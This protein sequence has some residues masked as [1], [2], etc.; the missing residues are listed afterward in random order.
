MHNTSPFRALRA[1]AVGTLAAAALSLA[2]AQATHHPALVIGQ[3]LALSGPGAAQARAYHDGAR[4]YFARLNAAGGVHGHKVDLRTLDDHGDAATVAAN[5]RKLLDMGALCLF[6]YAG[7]PQ[8][9]AAHPLARAAGVLLLA[10]QTSADA[11]HGPDFPNVYTMRAGYAEEA[12][13]MVRQLE[14]YGARRMAVLHA[15]DG[16]ALAALQAAQRAFGRLGGPVTHAVLSGNADVVDQALTG[17]P[18]AVVL[19]ADTAAT[20]LAVRQLRQRHFHGPIYGFSTAGEGLLAQ[21]LGA[22]GAGVVVARVVPRVENP[23]AAIAQRFLSDAGAA[24]AK[25]SVSMLEGYIAAHMLAEALR[26]A[27]PVPT[28]ARLRHAIEHM[29]DVDLGG[30]RVHYGKDR[31]G[32]RLIELAMIDGQGRLRE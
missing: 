4:L 24:D 26:R 9:A 6:G 17:R 1:A 8:V 18:D 15:T 3:S 29:H 7:A 25:P 2:Q 14:L 5:T 19:I 10:P 30:F 23:Q 32:S 12:A 22:D 11:F 27:G 13:A 21:Q 28:Q 20:A 31:M 16:E